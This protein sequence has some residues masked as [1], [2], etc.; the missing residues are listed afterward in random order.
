MEIL[1][2][3]IVKLKKVFSRLRKN[4]LKLNRTKCEFA[5]TQI[6]YLGHLISHNRFEPDLNKIKAIIQMPNP[7]N[8]KDIQRF[9]GMTNYLC[10]FI[11]KNSEIMTQLRMLPHNIL[12]SFDKP[13]IQAVENLKKI[14]KS[15]PILQFYNP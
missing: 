11:P 9:L 4:G 8:K 12:W 10:K 7:E 3:H 5:K 13:Q 6:T 2:D 14:I 15:T 1:E